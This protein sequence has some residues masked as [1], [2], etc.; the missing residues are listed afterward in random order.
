LTKANEYEYFRG[1]DLQAVDVDLKS[2]LRQREEEITSL[3]Y[4]T[5]HVKSS[6]AKQAGDA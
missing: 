3:K 5:D 6:N 2:K 4:E 1:K